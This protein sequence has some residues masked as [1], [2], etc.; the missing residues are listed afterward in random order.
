[1]LI[2]HCEARIAVA[3]CGRNWLAVG[4]HLERIA[5]IWITAEVLV[6]RTSLRDRI[7][8]CI[9]NYSADAATDHVILAAIDLAPL[10]ATRLH[11]L[12]HVARKRI[13]RFVIVVVCVER[14]EV[15]LWL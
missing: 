14:L 8:S 4:K 13:E 2:E 6:H 5:A 9:C 10:H 15:E 11:C 3:I 1:M 7:E 12:G